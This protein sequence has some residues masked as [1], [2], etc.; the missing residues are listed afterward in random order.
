MIQNLNA[1]RSPETTAKKEPYLLRPR[2]AQRLPTAA[3]ANGLAIQTKDNNRHKGTTPRG[4]RGSQGAASLIATRVSV[5]NAVS[6]APRAFAHAES[7]IFEGFGG[8]QR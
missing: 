6:L 7:E 1:R 8:G 3:S 2:S 4:F 5:Q